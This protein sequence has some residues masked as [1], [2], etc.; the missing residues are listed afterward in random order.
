MW[1]LEQY[2][3]RHTHDLKTAAPRAAPARPGEHVA[4]EID[5]PAARSEPKQC[6]HVLLVR[7]GTS[8]LALSRRMHSRPPDG[9][10]WHSTQ[11]RFAIAIAARARGAQR[12]TLR[13]LMP[14]LC[15]SLC[16]PSVCAF[17]RC[18][19]RGRACPRTR[20]S[21]A[22]PFARSC[23]GR[24]PS[25]AKDSWGDPHHP[26]FCMRR[27]CLLRHL[28]LPSPSPP[29]LLRSILQVVVPGRPPPRPLISERGA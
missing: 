8:S 7:S 12:T 17:H 25:V 4:H 21:H 26:S 15:A 13:P 19:I 27:L 10:H 28:R 2:S 5:S 1:L 22:A 3:I 18:H 9:T 6:I 11:L 24:F 14:P 16:M 23:R 29:N 20:C